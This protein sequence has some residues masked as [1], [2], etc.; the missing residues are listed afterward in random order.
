MLSAEVKEMLREQLKRVN[1]SIKHPDLT[2]GNT[3]T[4][5]VKL[6]G[7]L[8][9]LR[10]VGVDI[11]SVYRVFEGDIILSDSNSQEVDLA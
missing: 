2:T 9:A 5:C 8:E 7:M 6:A 11:L 4:E 1:Y 3:I 10:A